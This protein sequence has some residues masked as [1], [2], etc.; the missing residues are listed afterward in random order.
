MINNREPRSGNSSVIN[1]LEKSLE[2]CQSVRHFLV[3]F[4]ARARARRSSISSILIADSF[5]TRV[6]LPGSINDIREHPPS[7]VNF[8]TRHK[9]QLAPN[10]HH[11][12]RLNY[13]FDLF[14]GGVHESVRLRKIFNRRASNGSKKRAVNAR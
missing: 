12:C 4:P 8:L 11:H 2:L 1:S 6:P 14:R 7:P 10:R 9:S 3:H 5:A 13:L